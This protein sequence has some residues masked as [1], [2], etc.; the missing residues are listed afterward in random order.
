MY[1]LKRENTSSVFLAQ[2]NWGREAG[3]DTLVF[4]FK[5][6]FDKV[7]PSTLL[8]LILYYIL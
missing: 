4:D 6:V 7:V 8:L 3:L 5:S 1:H 2:C